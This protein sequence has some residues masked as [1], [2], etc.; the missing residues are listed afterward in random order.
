MIFFMNP[1]SMLFSMGI[2]FSSLLVA[3][4]NSWFTSWIGLEMN[5]LFFIMIMTLDKEFYSMESLIKYF[6]IQTL[7]SQFFLLNVMVMSSYK[8]TSMKLMTLILLL[9][10]GM[11]PLHWWFPSVAQNLS[12]DVNIV[13]MTLQKIAPLFILQIVASLSNLVVLLHTILIL[14]MVVSV[15]MG[16]NQ[17]QLRKLMAYSSM[18]HLSWMLF[19]ML[20]SSTMWMQYFFI[21]CVMSIMSMLNFKMNQLFTMNDFMK[22]PPANSLMLI[23][24]LLNLS[25]MPPLAGFYPKLMI[26]NSLIYNQMMITAMIIIILSLFSFF[27]YFRIMWSMMVKSHFLIPNYKMKPFIM[28]MSMMSLASTFLVFILYSF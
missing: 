6:L 9:K 15:F 16:L 20:S 24:M 19:S 11:P 8:L 12:W 27:F 2:L 26:L 25:G 4:M 17:F 23:I 21:Y 1:T 14:G 10:L 3:S 18:N 5:F 22:V 7:S 13:F 28:L